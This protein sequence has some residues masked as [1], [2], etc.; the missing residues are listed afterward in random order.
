MLLFKVVMVFGVH[1]FK[2]HEKAEFPSVSAEHLQE[3]DSADR[4]DVI[5]QS[6]PLTVRQC[7]SFW[8]F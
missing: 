7:F 3:L 4:S 1:V 2:V 5:V 8:A 6:A